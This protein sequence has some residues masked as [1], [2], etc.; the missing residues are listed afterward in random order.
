MSKRILKLLNGIYGWIIGIVAIA[1]AVYAGY[2][3]WDNSQIYTAAKNVQEE[4]RQLKPTKG[5][6]SFKKLQAINKD[7][8]AWI[9]VNG[10]NIDDP[11]LQGETN[12]T[13]MNHDIYGNYS[14][15]GSIFLDYRNKPD[16]SDNYSLVYGHNMDE[17]LM[18]GDL[19]LFKEKDFFKK[20]AKATLMLPGK[21]KYMNIAAVLQISA[22]T[23][24]IFQPETWSK[25]LNGMGEFLEK[26]SI[27]YDTGL[28]DLLK[29]RT[30]QMKVTALVTCSD[31]STND[32][33]A[34]ILVRDKNRNDENLIDGRNVKEG[35]TSRENHTN[36][37]D[38]QNGN[39]SGNESHGNIQTGDEQN[40][41]FWIRLMIGMVALIIVIEVIGGRR[42]K[43][44]NYTDE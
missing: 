20:H 43:K 4:I 42:R 40:T 9:T 41:A 2:S 29:T 12:L 31:G 33:T 13:Y 3:I 22:G 38:E 19:A 25:S 17:H 44:K 14:L 32:R 24:E 37:S 21:I 18:F 36:T 27:W 34:L 15:A 8:V 30:S 28:T 23:E 39:G 26:N 1:I 7:V 6:P 16:F 11:V 35:Q 10:T 5:K